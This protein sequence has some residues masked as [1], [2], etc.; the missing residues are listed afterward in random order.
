M[1]ISDITAENVLKYTRLEL[2]D[3]PEKGIIAIDGPNESGKSTIGEII[4][5][6]LFGQTFSLDQDGLQKLIRWGEPHCSVNVRFRIGD[7]QHYEIARF[8]DREGNQGA[9]LNLVGQEEKPISRGGEAV[10]LRLNELLG[11]GYDEF[12]ESFYLAQREITTPHPHSFA[13]KAMAGL[14]NLER[15]SDEYAS[16][17]EQ[18]RAVVESAEEEQR[19]VR[20][21]LDEVAIEDGLLAS[22]ESRRDLLSGEETARRQQMDELRQASVD[23]QETQPKI[24]AAQTSRTGAKSL[25][26]LLFIIA[27]AL[28][29]GWELLNQF[30]DQS[31]SKMLSQALTGQLPQWSEKHLPLLLYAGLGFSVLFLL[32][33][34]RVAIVNKRITE[35]GKSGQK[36]AER[37]AALPSLRAPAADSPEQQSN[38]D[39]EDAADEE[40]VGAGHDNTQEPPQD[41]QADTLPAAEQ[42]ESSEASALPDAA[43]MERIR[44]RIETSRAGAGEVRE[45]VDGVLQRMGEDSHR[46]QAEIVRLQVAVV[47]EQTRLGKA[48]GLQR[49]VDACEQKL[50]DHRQRIH[51]REIAGELLQGATRNLSQ[52]FNRDLRDLVGR[53]LPLFTENRY[54]HLQIDENLDVRAFSNEKRDFMGLDEISSGTQR[55]IMLAVRLALSQKLVNSAVSGRQFIFLDEPFA[56]FDEERTRSALSVLPELSEEI[57]QIWVVAQSFPAAQTFDVPIACSREHDVLPALV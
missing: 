37:L 41:D 17:I 25:R 43:Q 14:T 27:A 36:L 24:S 35:L 42:A 49:I 44:A 1:I 19:D 32:S 18:D 5:F 33:W 51:L 9:R 15:V 53:T 50:S 45:L 4:C 54:E 3:L 6:A 22:L 52:Q 10:E 57:T 55:Q 11:Y 38:S 28:L 56:F 20:A 39:S 31:L 23:Y 40:A 30:P 2:H 16:D 12:I 34:L 13:V 46:Q 47:D 7:G 8:L 29:I 26:F 21:E 48:E